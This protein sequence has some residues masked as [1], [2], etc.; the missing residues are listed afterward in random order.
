MTV[1]ALSFI[2]SKFPFPETKY[3]N[4]GLE[5]NIQAFQKADFRLFKTKGAA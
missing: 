2:S 4:E 5:G 1:N 3:M